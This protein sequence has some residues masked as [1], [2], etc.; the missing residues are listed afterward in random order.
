MAN[1]TNLSIFQ[2]LGQHPD[3][4]RRF[5]A[6]MRFFTKGEGWDLKH[7]VS[8]FG[9]KSMGRYFASSDVRTD[10][11]WLITPCFTVLVTSRSDADSNTTDYPG[12]IVVDMGGGAGSVSQYLARSTQVSLFGASPAIF[13][14]YITTLSRLH[15]FTLAVCPLFHNPWCFEEL[16]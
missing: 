7:L 14:V 11:R 5:G 15:E 1:G 9:W 2:F 12:A 3:R 10:S 6:G 4:G 13:G 8:G 16:C